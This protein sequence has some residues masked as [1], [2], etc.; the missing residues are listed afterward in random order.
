MVI[1]VVVAVGQLLGG[2]YIGRVVIFYD[3][4]CTQLIK[5]V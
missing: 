4:Q 1:V 2:G 3:L 5:Y